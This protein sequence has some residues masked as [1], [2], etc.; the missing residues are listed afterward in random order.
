MRKQMKQTKTKEPLKSG[1][2]VTRADVALARQPEESFIQR[3]ERPNLD[4]RGQWVKDSYAK[5]MPLADILLGSGLTVAGVFSLCNI[6][7]PTNQRQFD[8]LTRLRNET[9]LGR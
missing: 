6:D 2:E 1:L 3:I 8:E 4:N 5:G 7:I 9:I